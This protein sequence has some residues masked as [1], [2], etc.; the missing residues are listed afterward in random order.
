MFLSRCYGFHKTE[1]ISVCSRSGSSPAESRY[2]HHP[3]PRYSQHARILRT[4]LQRRFLNHACWITAPRCPF[5]KL[6]RR[7]KALNSKMKGREASP[8]LRM[9]P[10]HSSGTRSTVR[11]TEGRAEQRGAGGH[12]WTRTQESC[13]SSNSPARPP[14]EVGSTSSCTHP[15]PATSS[16]W[17]EAGGEMQGN[18]LPPPLLNLLYRKEIGIKLGLIGH[19]RVTWLLPNSWEA[20]DMGSSLWSWDWLYH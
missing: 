17:P 15:H 9:L 3:G 4:W 11:P 10:A 6:Q 16:C 18:Q 8:M 19:R 1:Q 5:S 12:S 14:A 7:I 2:L 13:C 20:K